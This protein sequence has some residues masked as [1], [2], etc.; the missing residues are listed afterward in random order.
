MPC[1]VDLPRILS[2]LTPGLMRLA[3]ILTGNRDTARDLVQETLLRLWRRRDT[4]DLIDDLPVYARAILRNLYRRALR[5]AAHEVVGDVPDAGIPPAV[6][7][8]LALQEIEAAIAHLPQDHATLLR[9]VLAGEFSPQALARRTGLPEG[10]VMSRLA[11]ARAQL[12]RDL[13]LAPGDKV[14]SLF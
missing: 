5:R 8:R 9:L 14:S 13:G 7:P 11:R 6:F 1:P 12:R 4:L 2:D 3:R 10:T